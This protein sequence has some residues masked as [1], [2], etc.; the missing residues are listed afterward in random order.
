MNT[1]SQTQ[2]PNERKSENVREEL[3]R[4]FDIFKSFL[5]DSVEFYH[6]LMT[7]IQQKFNLVIDGSVD[8]ELLS[9]NIN[10]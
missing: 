2:K 3:R 7:K 4:V 9:S 6:Q 8:Y 10:L 1:V 5:N